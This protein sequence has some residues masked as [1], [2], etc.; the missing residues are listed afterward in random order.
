MINHAIKRMGEVSIEDRNS[1]YCEFNDIIIA[2]DRNES[3]FEVL[4][5][6][7]LGTSPNQDTFSIFD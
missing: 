3:N 6:K 5:L 7:Y 1:I 2:L 4:Y